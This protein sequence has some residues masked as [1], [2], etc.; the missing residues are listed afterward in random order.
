MNKKNGPWTI[1]KRTN[2]YKDD[3]INLNVDDVI[4]PDGEKGT[5]STVKLIEGVSILA[6]DVNDIYLT[7]QYRYALETESVEVV[8]GAIDK[9]E[10]PL[11]AA[12]RELKE[13]LGITATKWVNLGY[14]EM[15]T[16]IVKC[17]VNIFLAQK[18]KFTKPDQ[19][20]TEDIKTIKTTLEE[21]VNKVMKSEII[22]SPSC[23]T[24][25]KAY[26]YLR[27]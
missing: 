6:L 11:Q 21:A 7:K 26:N 5:Y 1:K 27:N 20:G 18:I 4:Q 22:H 9:N 10:T 17:K 13:E 12:K 19:D 24:I 8:T 23:I 25:L 15:D 16:S 3:F 14:F 2:I